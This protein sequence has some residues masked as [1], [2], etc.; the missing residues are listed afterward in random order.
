MKKLLNSYV[1][2]QSEQILH[3]HKLFCLVSDLE[4]QIL[5]AFE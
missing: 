4:E 3:L 5:S 2:P 1:E